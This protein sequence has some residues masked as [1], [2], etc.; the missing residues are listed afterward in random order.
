MACG[1]R[2]FA[3]DPR[4]FKAWTDALHDGFDDAEGRIPGIRECAPVCAA[5]SSASHPLRLSLGG[6]RPRVARLCLAGNCRLSHAAVGT[7]GL[8][9]LVGEDDGLL[10]FVAGV[11]A[12]VG[13]HEHGIDLLETD[14]FGAVAHGFDE[15]AYTEVPDGPQDPFR[16]AQD[17]VERFVGEGVVRQ[18]GEIELGVEICFQGV[19]GEGVEFGGVGDAALEVAVGAELEGGVEG[20]LAEQDEVGVFGEVF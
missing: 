12:P 10:G 4:I 5:T 14:G 8:G 2:G 1:D 7:S 18:A 20:G 6:S 15:R 9:F 3:P 17:E 19:R 13:L 16:D 11:V